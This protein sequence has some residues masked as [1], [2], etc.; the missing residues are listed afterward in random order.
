MKVT[1]N[2]RFSE[3][4]VTNTDIDLR[5]S[6]VE[7]KNII[8]LVTLVMQPLRNELHLPLI[9]TSGY[10]NEELNNKVN[11]AW[12]SKHLDGSACD[13]FVKRKERRT[14]G[15]LD[16]VRMLRAANF[17]RLIYYV[18]QNRF[19]VQI[20]DKKRFYMKWKESNL[21]HDMTE[22]LYPLIIV[23]LVNEKRL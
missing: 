16:A 5:P 13:F 1:K 8:D 17:G 9:I 18:S 10:R 19:H 14:H 15:L 4:L 20:G 21:Y 22:D 3:F 11:G 7:K 12:N 2:F 23:P 6:Q